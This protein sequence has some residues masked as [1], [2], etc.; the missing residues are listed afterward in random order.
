MALAK[1][2]SF[3]YMLN[4]KKSTLYDCFKKMYT[5]QINSPKSLVELGLSYLISIKIELFL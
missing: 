3:Q 4:L 2:K 5:L 1:E